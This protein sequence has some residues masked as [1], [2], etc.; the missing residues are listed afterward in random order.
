LREIRF[1]SIRRRVVRYTYIPNTHN[2][3]DNRTIADKY[4]ELVFPRDNDNYKLIPNDFPRGART[5]CD[6]IIIINPSQ[7]NRNILKAS[8]YF[9]FRNIL[10]SR[11][12]SVYNDIFA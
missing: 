7:Q 2:N 6:N 3:D 8:E 12:A 4:S 5:I 1:N 9:I 10:S 11:L